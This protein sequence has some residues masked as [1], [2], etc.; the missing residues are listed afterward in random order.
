MSIG[1]PF[2]LWWRGAEVLSGMRHKVR[3]SRMWLRLLGGFKVIGS[4]SPGVFIGIAVSGFSFCLQRFPAGPT[5]SKSR[6]D[7]AETGAAHV[8]AS[9]EDPGLGRVA[10][11][12]GAV[13]RMS[14]AP[15]TSR[16]WI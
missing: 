15:G 3:V 14:L 2:V 10:W 12:G 4:R 1:G 9:Y 5:K 6:Y 11:D 7:G 13:P 16:S 8:G